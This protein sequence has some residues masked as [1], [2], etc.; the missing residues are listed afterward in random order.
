MSDF[1]LFMNAFLYINNSLCVA[2]ICFIHWDRGPHP[3]TL[4]LL[5]ASRKQSLGRAQHKARATVQLLPKTVPSWPAPAPGGHSPLQE[6]H[7][8]AGC[9]VH[10]VWDLFSRPP[11]LRIPSQVPY[12]AQAVLL[13]PNLF[14][15]SGV[16]LF[17]TPWTVACKLP[18]PWDS[19]G[20]NTGV[21]CHFLL[22]GI[23]PTQRSNPHL[24]HLL[25]WQAGSLPLSYQRSLPRMTAYVL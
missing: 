1:P 4:H 17:A 22:Q 14:S 13:L 9:G 15:R 3:C 21:C 7:V 18:C 20:K 12:V 19:P 24:W 11:D 5:K 16:S 10:T 23:F 25:H 8:S 2:S 6:W